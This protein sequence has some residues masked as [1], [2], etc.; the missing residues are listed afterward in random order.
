MNQSLDQRGFALCLQQLARK[1]AFVSKMEGTPCHQPRKPN[2][3]S[4][5]A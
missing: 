5:M 4:L 2:N 1:V 3:T